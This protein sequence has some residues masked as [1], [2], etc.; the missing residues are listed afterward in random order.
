MPGWLPRL[1]Q[2][3]RLRQI[4]DR[5]AREP[6]AVDARFERAS[7]LRALGEFEPA[8]NEYLETVRRAPGHFGALNDLGTLLFEHGFCSAARTAYGEAVRHHPSNPVG[9]VNLANLLLAAGEV[10]AARRHYEGALAI[11]PDDL[12]A[13]RGISNLL[14]QTG[15]HADAR[16]HRDKAYRGRS[17]ATLPYRGA[18]APVPVLLL[19]SALDGNIPTGALLD[20]RV[21]LTS[22]LVTEYWEPTCPLPPHC[23][24]FNGIGDADLCGEAL[25][26]AGALAD[27]AAVPVINRPAAVLDTGRRANAGRLGRLPDVIAPRIAAMPRGL[28]LGAS[29][30]DALASR[31]FTFPLLVRA[32]GFHTGRHFARIDA[33]DDLAATVACLPGSELWVIQYVDARGGDGK[34]RKYR[35]MIVDGALYPLHL[36][37]SDHWKVHYYTADMAQSPQHRAED[38]AFLNDMGGVLGRRAVRGLE[39]IRDT[40]GLDYAGVDFALGPAGEVVLF[41]ANAAM[42]VAA[43]TAEAKWDYRRGPVERILRAVRAMLLSRASGA[44]RAA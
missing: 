41:E 1:S 44:A 40:L 23:L 5:V 14:A 31:G 42:T 39:Q 12:H 37:V 27:R 36:A 34:A 15:E 13:H 35:I 25:R 11:D 29:A 28:L 22:A 9:H 24:I 19:V 6:D 30:R 10:D 16:R 26:S 20:D 2:E 18:R 3:E 7:L 17:I 21:F 33:P 38:A 4:T 32:P 43:P 8:K